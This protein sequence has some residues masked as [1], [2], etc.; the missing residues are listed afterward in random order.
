MR[1]RARECALQILYLMDMQGKLKPSD[2]RAADE[3]IIAGFWESFEGIE[4]DQRD[5]AMRLVTGV[6]EGLS[7]LDAA[8]EATTHRWK[9]ARM[10]EVDRNLLRLGAYEILFC[11]DI[12]RGASINEA[13]E[14]AKRFSGAES[15]SFVNGILDN[16]EPIAPES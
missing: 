6:R 15:F 5:F 1:R 16:L 8:I 14:L 10:P 4:G 7:E 9:L 2:D 12:P 3:A 13:V 11:P